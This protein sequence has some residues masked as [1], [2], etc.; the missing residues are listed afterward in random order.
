MFSQHD[1]SPFSI[2]LFSNK[3]HTASIFLTVFAAKTSP[4]SS[5]VADTVGTWS[6]SSVTVSKSPS[7]VASLKPP[8]RGISNDWDSFGEDS[9][10]G[11]GEGSST[12]ADN[13]SD[14][15]KNPEQSPAEPEPPIEQPVD[16]E[17]LP[18]L[19][20]SSDK[21]YRRPRGKEADSSGAEDVTIPV[22]SSVSAPAPAMSS[23]A[24]VAGSSGVKPAA[25]RGRVRDYTVL[26]P[27]CVSVCNVTIQ[28][29]I[30]RS[31]DDFV[32]PV[33]ADIGES[34]SF[35]RKADTQT[36]KPTRYSPNILLSY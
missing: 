13:S 32:I 3:R 25:G 19:K 8:S 15:L 6:K 30:E 11:A 20:P 29:S 34:G 4:A 21:V 2:V 28:D 27:S 31:V 16:F 36:A 5:Y 24:G 14:G 1:V 23:S 12:Q 26:H 7:Q 9:P 10:P 33:Q 35:R 17:Q 22:A 18:L